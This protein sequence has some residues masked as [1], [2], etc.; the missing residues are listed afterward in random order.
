MKNVWNKYT[1]EDLEQVTDLGDRYKSFL[2]QCKTERDGTSFFSRKAEEK[3]YV[4]IGQLIDTGY[5]LKPGDKIYA[6]HM[7]KT[8]AFFHVGK[9]PLTEGMNILCAHID[10]PRMDLKQVPSLRIRILS[11]WI[12]AI[13]EQ[14]RN[15]SGSLFHLPFMVWWQRKMEML[16]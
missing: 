2:S 10:S 6:S 13:M 9:K 5:E 16:F 15:I 1:E 8:V 11:I 4:N 12:P 7:G 14:S 3:G